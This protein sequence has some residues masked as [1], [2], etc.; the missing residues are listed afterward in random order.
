[1]VQRVDEWKRR[2]TVKSPSIVEGGG[3]AN[4]GFVDIGYAEIDFSH[5]HQERWILDTVLL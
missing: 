2:S 4:G 3:N 1:M 5:L